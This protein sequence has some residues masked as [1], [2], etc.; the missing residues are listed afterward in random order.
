MTSCWLGL[1]AEESDPGGPTKRVDE[2]PQVYS[3]KLTPI[4]LSKTGI[5]YFPFPFYLPYLAIRV[6]PRWTPKSGH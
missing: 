2:L 3:L 4:G 1:D 6:P 5:Q